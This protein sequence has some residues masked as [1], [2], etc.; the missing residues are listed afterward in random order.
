MRKRNPEPLPPIPRP[1][2]VRERIVTAANKLFSIWGVSPLAASFSVI[3]QLAETNSDTVRDYVGSIDKLVVP[4]LEHESKIECNSRE[5]LIDRVDGDPVRQVREWLD[6]NLFAATEVPH[7]E[8]RGHS[9]SNAA[10][11][12]APMPDHKGRRVVFEHKMQEREWLAE[13]CCKA[14]YRD[15]MALADTLILLVEGCYVAAAAC[16]VAG[17]ASRFAEAAEEQLNLHTP[18]ADQTMRANHE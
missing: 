10:I 11:A 14:G 5:A 18:S 16:G 13:L 6:F 17:A 9:L 7:R 15:P 2:P 1:P 12:L 3:A 4:F 8:G